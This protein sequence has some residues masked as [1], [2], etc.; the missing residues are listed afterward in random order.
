M[1][2]RKNIE[3]ATLCK[4]YD[5]DA[6]SGRPAAFLQGRQ[7]FARAYRMKLRDIHAYDASA[8]LMN[9]IIFCAH[10]YIYKFDIHLN[11]LA[12]YVI[13]TEYIYYAYKDWIY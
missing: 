8:N 5:K 12:I 7:I 11:A 1:S 2:T 3:H 4:Y 10:T 9:N 13:S 6:K